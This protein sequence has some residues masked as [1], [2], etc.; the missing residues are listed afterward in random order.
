MKLKQTCLCLVAALAL[1]SA[2]YAQSKAPTLLITQHRLVI[3]G[4]SRSA[5]IAVSNPGGAR[6]SYKAEF[7]NVMTDDYGKGT[8]YEPKA[9]TPASLARADKLIR[10]SPRRFTLNPSEY[11]NIRLLV[12]IPKDL[13][14]GEYRPHLRVTL[15][16]QDTVLTDEVEETLNNKGHVAVGARS[17]FSYTVPVIL[18]HGETTVSTSIS[19]ISYKPAEGEEKA[20]IA[21]KI[22][23]E[24]NQ[25]VHGDIRVTYISK[26]GKE[27]LVRHMGGSAVYTPNTHRLYDAEL[28]LPEGLTIDGGRFDI[29]YTEKPPKGSPEGTRGDVLSK[30]SLEL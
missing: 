16:P 12:R 2:A 14:H 19:D 18:R 1:S 30:G 26:A 6:G 21:F 23:R 11:Q 17:T 25:S 4:K 24:G 29:V 13:E 28:R 5:V 22:T 10:L 8:T 15:L 27:Y 7:V 9:E 20:R 3:E